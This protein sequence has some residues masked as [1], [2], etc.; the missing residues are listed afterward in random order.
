MKPRRNQRSKDSCV[1]VSMLAHPL[2]KVNNQ[3]Q[4]VSC[5]SDEIF[6]D[7]INEGKKAHNALMKLSQTKKTGCFCVDEC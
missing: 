4:C 7:F 3:E 2:L 6:I 5:W 1:C